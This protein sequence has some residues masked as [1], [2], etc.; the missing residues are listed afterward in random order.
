MCHSSVRIINGES[1]SYSAL[2]PSCSEAW[3]LCFATLGAPPSTAR[4]IESLGSDQHAFDPCT[5][6]GGVLELDTFS[7]LYCLHTYAILCIRSRHCADRPT[8]ALVTMQQAPCPPPVMASNPLPAN[9]VFR[10]LRTRL[11]SRASTATLQ[12][13]RTSDSIETIPVVSWNSRRFMVLQSPGTIVPLEKQ[14]TLLTSQVPDCFTCMPPSRSPPL[15][16]TVTIPP[17]IAR[18]T[19]PLTPKLKPLMVRGWRIRSDNKICCKLVLAPKSILRGADV[20]LS[21]NSVRQHSVRFA[22]PSTNRYY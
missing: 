8:R 13:K 11:S 7:L 2:Q 6:T 9:T 1:L 19:P 10:R 21:P 16:P 4:C 5:W 22:H 3:A 18:P 20:R 17:P 14:Q 15:K 12:A